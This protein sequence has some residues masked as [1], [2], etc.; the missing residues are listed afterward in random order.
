MNTVFVIHHPQPAQLNLTSLPDHIGK[1]MLY[2]SRTLRFAVPQ[3]FRPPEACIQALQQQ[4]ADWAV[5]PDVRFDHFRLIVSDMDATLIATESLDEIAAAAGLLPHIAPITQAAMNGEID[6][7][8]ALRQRIQLFA[9]LPVSLLETIWHERMPL[10]EGAL[11]LLAECRQSGA[12]VLLASG[13]LTFFTDRLRQHLGLAAAHGNTA[14]IH[15]HHLTGQLAEPI[16][17]AHAKAQLLEQHRLQ[18]G[19]T[20]DQV[21]AIG[22]GA[23]DIPMLQTAGVGIAFRAKIRVAQEADACIQFGALDAVRDLFR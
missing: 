17:D 12:D 19:L 15:N 7:T 14:L 20:R 5:L 8:Q 21:L 6:F 22:D 2:R 1:G 16:L 10:N 3:G 11:N 4:Q 23:N 13:G 18:R 9:G